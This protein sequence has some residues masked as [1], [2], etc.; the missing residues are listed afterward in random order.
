MEKDGG[1]ER[2]RGWYLGTDVL[3]EME[4]SK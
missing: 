3:I 2:K 4:T 1:G